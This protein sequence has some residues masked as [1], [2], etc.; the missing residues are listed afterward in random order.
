MTL[1]SPNENA[2]SRSHPPRVTHTGLLLAVVSRCVCASVCLCQ[3][4]GAGSCRRGVP[5]LHFTL[6]FLSVKWLSVSFKHHWVHFPSQAA[7]RNTWACACAAN[8]FANT[9]AQQAGERCGVNTSTNLTQARISFAK[10]NGFSRWGG[11]LSCF[12]C[13]AHMDSGLVRPSILT[14]AVRPPSLNVCCALCVHK[15]SGLGGECLPSWSPTVTHSL[16]AVL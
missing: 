5:S 16:P 8:I 11:L 14:A 6:M 12:N 2:S 10:L 4:V 13:C 3:S 15:I 7:R 1:I 9:C